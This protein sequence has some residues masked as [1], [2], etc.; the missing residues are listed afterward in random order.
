MYKIHCK[1]QVQPDTVIEFI[2]VLNASSKEVAIEK[3][4]MIL[5][6]DEIIDCSLFNPG[7]FKTT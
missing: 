7:I 1:A 2:L 6:R 5:L 4:K 3:A